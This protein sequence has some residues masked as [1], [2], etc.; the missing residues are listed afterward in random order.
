MTTTLNVQGAGA[1]QAG[2]ASTAASAPPGAAT[3]G[4]AIQDQFLK[5]LITQMKNQD[6][7]NPMD[8]AQMTT[9]MAQI[10]SLQGIEQLNTTMQSLAASLA[11]NQAVQAATLIGHDVMVA[12]N[13]LQ[14]ANGHAT[15]AVELVQA[16]DQVQVTITNG[17]GAVVHRADLGAQPQGIVQID[18]DGQTD[19]GAAAVAGNYRFS[20]TATAQGGSVG[21]QPLMIG[22]V[23]GVT[24]A[25]G[26]TNVDLGSIG[27]VS[28]SQVKQFM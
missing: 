14:L 12:G 16:A 1:S 17:A 13:R 21:A 7:L 8:S 28:L 11:G 19:A 25:N 4:S 9:Q 10:S 22:H 24:A 5:L 27:S 6:P 15:G 3:T 18:W 23:Q 20:V 26:S 2:A